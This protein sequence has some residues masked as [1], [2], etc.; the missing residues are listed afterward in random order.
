MGAKRIAFKI[1]ISSSLEI[2]LGRFSY[3]DVLGFIEQHSHPVITGSPQSEIYVFDFG[4]GVDRQEADDLGIHP[5]GTELVA[6]AI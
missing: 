3:K 2:D 6:K 4:T 5:G 1:I